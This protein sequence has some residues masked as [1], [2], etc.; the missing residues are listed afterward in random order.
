ME[1]SGQVPFL[2]ECA[3]ERCTEIVRLSLDCYEKVR[4]HPRRFFNALGHQRLS[5][6]AG[7][8]VVVEE[9]PGYVVVDKID[10][11]GEVAEQRYDELSE[12]SGR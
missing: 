5:V 1:I 6:S 7:A 3:D 2:C 4:S 12:R 10:L 8:A 11:A 9:L